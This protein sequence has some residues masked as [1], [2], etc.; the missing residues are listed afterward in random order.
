M[1]IK[2][3]RGGMNSNNG[4]DKQRKGR[5]KAKKGEQGELKEGL[6]GCKEGSVKKKWRGG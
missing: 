1:K 6:V 3:R 4:E 5:I 2:Q